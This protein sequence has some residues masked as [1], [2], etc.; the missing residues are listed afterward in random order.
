MLTEPTGARIRVEVVEF[1]GKGAELTVGNGAAPS[2]GEVNAVL[3]TGAFISTEVLSVSSNV[4]ITLEFN[5][6]MGYLGKLRV[7]ST[8]YNTTGKVKTEI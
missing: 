7:V 8:V 2:A 3:K 6:P 1:A 4:W 5:E